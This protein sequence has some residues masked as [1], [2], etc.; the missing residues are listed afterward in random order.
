MAGFKVVAPSGGL[1]KAQDVSWILGHWAVLFLLDLLC[2]AG[3]RPFC[4][5]TP[6]L[7]ETPLHKP[8]RAEQSFT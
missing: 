2:T 6:V 3:L 4:R 5:P 8:G 1:P 7:Q